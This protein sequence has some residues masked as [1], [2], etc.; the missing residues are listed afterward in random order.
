[1]A[2]MSRSRSGAVHGHERSTTT[3]PTSARTAALKRLERKLQRDSTALLGERD[4][5]LLAAE[6]RAAFA[7]SFP[8]VPIEMAGG[9]EDLVR[10]QPLGARCREAR[11]GRGW[12]YRDAS[13]ATSIPQYRIKAV[14]EGRLREVKPDLAR[15]YFVALGMDGWVAG[16]ARANQDLAARVL[17]TPTPHRGSRARTR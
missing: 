6:V 4:V 14:E 17:G 2:G 16:W 12:S 3:R 8:H 10:W 9:V 7:A 1:M 11:A 15:R 13:A 5:S